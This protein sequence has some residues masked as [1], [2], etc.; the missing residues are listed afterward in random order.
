MNVDKRKKYRNTYSVQIFYLFSVAILVDY[1]G[2][3]EMWC[4]HKYLCGNNQEKISEPSRSNVFTKMKRITAKKILLWP[5][6]SFSRILEYIFTSI[7]LF[8]SYID[9]CRQ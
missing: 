9:I 8:A 6:F 7:L 1:E 5:F 3:A 2:I 4:R